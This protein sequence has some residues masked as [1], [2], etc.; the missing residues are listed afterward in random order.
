M[1]AL[2]R[3]DSGPPTAERIRWVPLVLALEWAIEHP[4]TSAPRPGPELTRELFQHVA[5][6]EDVRVTFR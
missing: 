2:A 5:D 1:S 3:F 4:D 6:Q